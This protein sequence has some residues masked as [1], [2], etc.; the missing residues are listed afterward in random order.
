MFVFY[1]CRFAVILDVPSLL[2]WSCFAA[3]CQMK[4]LKQ[5]FTVSLSSSWTHFLTPC[6]CIEAGVLLLCHEVSDFDLS[7]LEDNHRSL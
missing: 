5:F 2:L 4:N 1:D 6:K 7:V 3:N